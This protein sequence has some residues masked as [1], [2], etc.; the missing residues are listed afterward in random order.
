MR[1]WRMSSA[2]QIEPGHAP[3][4]EE[5]MAAKNGKNS[6]LQKVRVV[7]C[8]SHS[9]LETFHTRFKIFIQPEVYFFFLHPLSR[10]T[11]LH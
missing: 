11:D 9:C 6:L 8:H 2:N 5:K 7:Y 1:A 10:A 3:D 4:Q